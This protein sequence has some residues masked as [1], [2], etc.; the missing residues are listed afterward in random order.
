MEVLCHQINLG[1]S[2]LALEVFNN[3]LKDRECIG[4]I[5][6]PYVAFKRVASRPLGYIVFPEG[7]QEA[8]P[9]AALFIPETIKCVGLPHLSNRD[10][11]TALIYCLGKTV[12][13]ASIYLDGEEEEEVVPDWLHRIVVYAESKN[14]DVLMCLDS[15]AHSELFGSNTD[16][17]GE[18]IEEFIFQ[19]GL[20]VDNRGHIPT[21]QTSRGS[22]IIDITLSK[23]VD[24]SEWKTMEGYNASDHN[25][26]VFKIIADRVPGKDVRAWKDADWSEF[27]KILQSKTFS[28]PDRVT[29]KKLDKMVSFLYATL[30][31][32]LDKACPIRKTK[33]RYKGSHWFSKVLERK[34]R[35]V[36]RQYDIAIRAPVEEEWDKY[37]R[38]HGKFK[39][40]CRRAKT[41]SW[42][43]F[44]SETE[45]ENKMSF[46]SR[47]ALHNDRKTLQVLRNSTGDLTEPGKE[48]ITELARVHFPAASA[49]VPQ[50]KYNSDKSVLRDELNG[51]Y[52][53]FITP[54]KVQLA[55]N[56]FKPMKAPGPDGLKPIVF[57][58]LSSNIIEFISVIYKACLKLHY[59]PLLWQ[60]TRV[61]FIPKP[62]K[63]T[64]DEAK[65]FRPISLSNFLLKGLER[66]IT[67]RMEFFLDKYYPIHEK[68]HGFMKGR[69]TESAISNTVDYIEGWLA[70]EKSC[71]G[72]FLDISSA[73]DSISI[74][75][76]RTALYKHGGET[77][78][79]EW[80][81]HYLGHRSMKISL[82]GEELNL[83][84]AVGFPQ[85]GVC[86]AKFWTVAFDP[87]IQL[88]NSMF[89]EGNGYADDCC[90]V[91][92]GRSISD[93]LLR[94]QRVLDRL[95]EWGETCGLRFNAEKTEV[96]YFSRG[97]SSP[98]QYLVM[99]GNRI[100]YSNSAKYLGVILDRRLTWTTHVKEKCK[101]GKQFLLKMAQ[102]SKATWGP[103]PHLMKWV[104]R[105]VV[106]PMVTYGAMV[107]AHI[108]LK[109]GS[110]VN[111]L[112][113]LNR[114]AIC[115]LT[116][117]PRSLPTQALEVLVDLF[118][119]HIWIQKEALC[120]YIR[121]HE[122]LPLSWSGMFRGSKVRIGHRRAWANKVEMLGVDQLLLEIDV[123]FLRNTE[124]IFEVDTNSFHKDIQY[125]KALSKKDWS[126]FTDGS[127][128]DGRVGAAFIILKDEEL[129]AEEFYRLSDES[130][131]FQAEVF[132][133]CKA[134]E[135]LITKAEQESI[136]GAGRLFSD[137]QSAL[138]AVCSSIVESSVVSKAIRLLNE[139]PIHFSLHWIKAHAGHPYNEAV[140]KLAKRG[141]ELA[142]ISVMPLPR[143]MIRVQV[144]A[145][146]REIWESEWELYGEARQSKRFL[147]KTNRSRGKSVCYLNRVDLR[148]LFLAITGHNY[149]RYH[150]SLQNPE[151]DPA[152]RY[153]YLEPESFIHFL[154]NCPAFVNIKRNIFKD[155]IFTVGEDDWK[156][157]DMMEFI[158]HEKVVHHLDEL[159]L[160]L[161]VRDK[162]ETEEEPVGTNDSEGE[163][164]MDIDIDD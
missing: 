153:C 147:V 137:S 164:E 11:Q 122:R 25:D 56:M 24:V 16:R 74:E 7:I 150:M 66:L 105:C 129:W 127:K 50:D 31:E 48:T 99:G 33:S 47:I 126:V 76:I 14:F 116:M 19:Y 80:Y 108:L 29:C 158:K 135:F 85:G 43:H 103:K 128:K 148:R 142:Y 110:C 46:L 87:A 162:V 26:I 143:S 17:R 157:S 1:R 45:N 139:V 67:W 79:V 88:V 119:L 151:I 70:K 36:K 57:R 39:S 69:S 115:T 90:V 8:N 146:L 152:C 82:Q 111:R 84:T 91:F 100:E 15:N 144:I 22:S 132:A 42:R 134:M 58:H 145:K 4:F 78:V 97:F 104:F 41:A 96:V 92:G 114:L 136:S 63:K 71:I 161:L 2:S 28:V 6:E 49:D 38:M 149:L 32:A 12:V 124:Q 123:C 156:L 109:N 52:S 13:V 68:Q 117:F 77:D 30:E 59:T 35:K 23:R 140:D 159:D 54:E 34:Q 154:E 81:F 37:R 155:W 163:S 112:R 44:V 65:S 86:S 51:A 125:V 64:Y 9:R 40:E 101:K 27:T 72:V 94:L 3:K 160:S 5:M 18:H 55:L 10:C 53:A 113:K 141:T 130:T 75:H 120:A 62:G 118:L 61:V 133:I 106:R 98:D 93:M 138:Q 73:Y 102:I 60:K 21:F 121:L 89:L 131:V 20:S 83:H 95:V 107:W